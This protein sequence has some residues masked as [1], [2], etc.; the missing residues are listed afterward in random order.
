MTLVAAH[1]AAGIGSARSYRAQQRRAEELAELDRAKTTFFS[2]ISHEFRTPLTL[3]L[4]PVAELRGRAA[5]WTTTTRQE[6]DVVWRNGLRLTKLVNTL[7]DFSRIEAGRAQARYE[8]VDLAAVTAELASVFRSAIDRAGLEF[9]VDCPPMDEPVY[10]DRDMWEKVILNLLS[11]ALKFT[12]DGSIS[13]AVRRGEAT[14]RSSPSPTPESVWPPRRCLG[15]SNGFT[16]SRP[17]TRDPTRAAGSGWHWSRSWSACTAA[18]STPT[19]PKAW[20]PR[21]RFVCRSAPRICP[22]TP[23]LSTGGTLAASGLAEPYVQEALRWMPADVEPPAAEAAESALTPDNTVVQL[24]GRDT[25][26]RVLIADDNTDMRE[27]LARLLGQ[28]RLPRRGGHRW[29]ARAGCHPRRCA[30]PRG[31]RRDDAPA[32]RTGPGCRRCG[33]IP[34]PRPCRCCCCPHEPGRK[35]PSKACRP[36]PTTISSSRSQPPNSSRA[37]A[38]SSNWRGCATIMRAG[39]RPSSTRCKK[40]SSSATRR[41]AV[42]EINAAFTDILGYGTDGL[43]YE[44]E[45]PVVAVGRH[46]PHRLPASPAGIRR[47]ARPKRTAP[48]RFQWTTATGTGS[49]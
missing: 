41:G 47:T 28:R 43:P 37:C 2:N 45:L 1:I 6:L 31:Q 14:T 49:G 5:G 17:H 11:N 32:G 20:A 10:I 48:S 19:A 12:F 29:P 42:I 16:A 46:R 13:V 36:A 15:C 26:A 8:P 38:A 33:P 4:D 40:P 24:S 18:A 3:I 25:T 22:P 34:A 35:P 21:S 44:A 39:A 30:R 7:L 27:Y 9:T 23:S